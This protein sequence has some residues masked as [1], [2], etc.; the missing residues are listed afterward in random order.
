MMA[1]NIKVDD[2]KTFIRQLLDG[3]W[4]ICRVSDNGNAISIQ[5]VTWQYAEQWMKNILAKPAVIS[6]LA[7]L[8][9]EEEGY[10]ADDEQQIAKNA[11]DTI[12]REAV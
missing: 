9:G 10:P 12:I 2:C 1:R 11:I 4:Q 8:L 3:S 6:A 5:D 7:G